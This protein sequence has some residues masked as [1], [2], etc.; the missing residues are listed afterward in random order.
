MRRGGGRRDGEAG[1]NFR[2]QRVPPRSQ[3]PRR[4]VGA[5][6]CQAGPL[7]TYSQ[8][9][10]IN[11]EKAHARMRASTRPPAFLPPRQTAR[12]ARVCPPAASA[13]PPAAGLGA[14]VP[15]TE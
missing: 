6:A 15:Y 7:H 2:S 14:A 11:T 1:R 12:P 4:R 10:T 9:Q 8:R 5:A 13:R 3:R